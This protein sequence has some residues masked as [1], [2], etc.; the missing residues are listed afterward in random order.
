VEKCYLSAH[1]QHALV[2]RH[3]AETRDDGRN[4][5][6]RVQSKQDV[7]HTL[8]DKPESP[9]SPNEPFHLSDFDAFMR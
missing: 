7:T 2:V 3:P 6:A 5:G 8:A 1:G 4:V 9:F